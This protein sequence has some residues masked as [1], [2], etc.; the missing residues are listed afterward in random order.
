M[1]AARPNSR[2]TRRPTHQPIQKSISHIS[3]VARFY[4]DVSRVDRAFDG[5]GNRESR[6]KVLVLTQPP[7]LNDR[8]VIP[9][10]THR[11][12]IV[13]VPSLTVLGSL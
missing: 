10:G 6:V 8:V 13:A 12:R 9:N 4:F 5:I 7:P 2:R 11:N 3:P 1:I